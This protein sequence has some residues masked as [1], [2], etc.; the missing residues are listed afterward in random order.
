MTLTFD[1]SPDLEQQLHAQIPDLQKE[2]I[3]AMLVEFYRQDKI[4]RPQLAQ[5]LGLCRLEVD[6]VLKAHNVTENVPTPEELRADF[7]HLS[8]LVKR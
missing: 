6:A 3:E 4:T 5:A 2:G 1:L 8:R 7:E